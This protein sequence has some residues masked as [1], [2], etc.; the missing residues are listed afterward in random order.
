MGEPLAR[1]D[2][3]AESVLAEAAQR[4]ER[5]LHTLET[6]LGR[7]AVSVA[8]TAQ[9]VELEAVRRRSR[10]L[11][12]AAAET[13]RTLGRA[14]AEV[15]RA[16]Q[17]DELEA[18]DPQTS[19]FDAGLF[20]GDTPEDGRFDSPLESDPGLADDHDETAAARSAAEKEPTE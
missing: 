9:V 11:E 16:L 6:A 12:T 4:L 2:T 18:D 5:A 3:A 17:E 19:L 7:S 8:D 14:M 15:R 13:S 1:T 10:E 20:D